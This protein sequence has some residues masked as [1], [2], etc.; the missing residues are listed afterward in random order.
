MKTGVANEL[1]A[2]DGFKKRELLEPANRYRLCLGF[3]LFLGQQ[4]TGMTALY[5]VSSKLR[6]DSILTDHQPCLGR[7]LHPR[8]S[9]FLWEQ[10]LKISSSPVFSA[11]KN[12]SHAAPTYSLS[13]SDGVEDRPFGSLHC[14]WERFSSSSVL[15]TRR[16]RMRKASST[17]GLV[18]A[19]S[20]SSF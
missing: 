4:C 11:L 9:V 14:L 2:S 17:E 5:V 7:T 13:R 18:S 3:G 19:L 16:Q 6:I 10:V 1:K 15:S 8:F 20:Y 12:S